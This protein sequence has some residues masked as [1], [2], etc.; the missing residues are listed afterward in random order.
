MLKVQSIKKAFVC[1]ENFLKP[2]L[3]GIDFELKE[4]EFCV[5][6]G[7]NGAGKSTMIKT[8]LGIFLPDEGSVFLGNT[9]IAKIPFTQRSAYVTCVSQSLELNTVSEL[10]VR[11]NLM[12]SCMRGQ[13]AH[14]LKMP[15]KDKD[16]FFKRE[17]QKLDMGLENSL[18]QRVRSFSGGQ[19]QALAM[20]M[21]FIHKPKLLLLD[22]H[23]SALDPKT[24]ERVMQ[25]TERR[26]REEKITTLMITHDLRDALYYGD[27]LLML[28]E[29]KI[30]RNFNREEKLKLNADMLLD[31]YHGN[32]I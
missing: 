13:K 24:N 31:L 1:E 10:T 30:V 22:E 14:L 3:R 9:S 7:S 6:I 8:I 5:L 25:I 28:H 29:G 19:R 27:R 21:A 20:V 11:E 12:I 23:T 17:L 18:D 15:T 32:G 4:G 2:I 26:V 16:I